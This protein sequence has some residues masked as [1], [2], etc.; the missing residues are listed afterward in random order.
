MKAVVQTGERTRT[1]PGELGLKGTTT[2][3]YA[4]L[5]TNASP[6]PAIRRS[7]SSLER[8]D[9]IISALCESLQQEQKDASD[10]DGLTALHHAVRMKKLEAVNPLLDQG[11]SPNVKDRE[12]TTPLHYAATRKLKKFVKLIS[13]VSTTEINLTDNAGR[14]PLHVAVR[15]SGFEIVELLLAHGAGFDSNASLGQG[16]R[17]PDINPDTKKLLDSTESSRHG[18]T[19]SISQSHHRGQDAAFRGV[20]FAPT[21]PGNRMCWSGT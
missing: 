10:S 4:V 11:A 6:T 15:W 18:R 16:L 3:I 13:T 21:A 9:A 8:H 2:L 17:P 7:E 1:E 20:R 14:T 19:D 12:G 5:R